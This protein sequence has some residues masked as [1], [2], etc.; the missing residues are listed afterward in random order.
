ML[1]MLISALFTG[2]GTSRMTIN[3]SFWENKT[4]KI[5]IVIGG[6][7]KAAAYKGGNQGLLDIAINEAMA[8]SL[9]S[10]LRS[11][12]MT[13][14]SNIADQFVL[15]LKERGL[16]VTKLTERGFVDPD[17]SSSG[18]KKYISCNFKKLMQKEPVDIVL[19]LEIVR[20]GTI[21]SYY[22]FIPTSDPKALCQARAYLIST[23]DCEL[24]WTFEM[25]EKESIVPV[26]GAWDQSPDYPN[27]TNALNAAMKEA[28]NLIINDFFKKD[29]NDK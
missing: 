7:P 12:D 14:F 24:L 9:E 26:V 21:R 28:G 8:G 11:V 1:A 2:C 4:Q 25:Q 13:P 20:F 23:K 3:P 16:T 27:V 5:G 18:G 19:F 29:A 22:G 10:H 6:F 15:Q 17:I